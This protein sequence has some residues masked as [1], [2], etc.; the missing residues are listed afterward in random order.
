MPNPKKRWEFIVG[1]AAA[2]RGRCTQTLLGIIC[3]SKPNGLASAAQ[4]PIEPEKS[5][6]ALKKFISVHLIVQLGE[7]AHL[8]LI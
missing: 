3:M 7:V 4:R 6:Q 5:S 8:K 2:V 1:S